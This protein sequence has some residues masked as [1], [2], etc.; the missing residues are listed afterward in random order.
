MATT[1]ETW[2][3]SRPGARPGTFAIWIMERVDNSPIATVSW[4]V[5]GRGLQ[6]RTM[7][8]RRAVDAG[9]KKL[10]GEYSQEYRRTVTQPDAPG[11]VAKAPPAEPAQP[12]EQA[13]APWR[14]AIN[15]EILI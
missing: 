11:K 8:Y 14:D 3:L 15:W 7:D 4:G 1:V 13:R 10:R 2:K 5:E 12:P 9:E 6:S